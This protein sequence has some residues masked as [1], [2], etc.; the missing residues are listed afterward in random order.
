MGKSKSTSSMRAH[1]RSRHP[2]AIA[3]SRVEESALEYSK[4]ASMVV[5]AMIRCVVYSFQ[6]VDILFTTFFRDLNR[7]INRSAIVPDRD[8]VLQ[9]IASLNIDIYNV[10]RGMIRG[11]KVYLLVNRWVSCDQKGFESYYVYYHDMWTPTCH[12]IHTSPVVRALLAPSGTRGIN[13]ADGDSGDNTSNDTDRV[14][15]GEDERVDTATAPLLS[16]QETVT[17]SAESPSSVKSNSS[18]RIIEANIV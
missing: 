12:H 6:P 15:S 5:D 10:I 11:R 2:T 4:R 8:S 13:G 1:L 17:M 9:R 18:D 7:V 16:A 14:K 3:G